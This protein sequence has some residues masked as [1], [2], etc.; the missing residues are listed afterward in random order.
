MAGIRRVHAPAGVGWLSATSLAAALDP[1]T[2][3]NVRLPGV[4]GGP[5]AAATLITRCPTRRAGAPV[6]AISPRYA[7]GTINASKPTAG[8]WSSP[9]QHV[10][11]VDH[12][13]W[14]PLHDLSDR[15][16]RLSHSGA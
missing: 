7:A 2:P 15:L 13:Q 1:G 14:T 8:R 6:S 12:P 4:L 11:D 10:V 16:S 5:R 3:A 9:A